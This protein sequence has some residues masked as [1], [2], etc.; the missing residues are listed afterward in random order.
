MRKLARLLIIGAL[1]ASML[2][3]IALAADF[4]DNSGASTEFENDVI[5]D[6]I[7][8]FG[9]QRDEAEP[10]SEADGEE[11]EDIENPDDDGGTEEEKDPMS[12]L[13]TEKHIQY[14]SGYEDGTFRPEDSITRY[15]VATMFA[16][17]LREE[18]KDAPAKFTDVPDSAWYAKSVNALA[19][20]EILSGREEKRFAPEEPI[21][22]GEIAAIAAKFV[23]E[24]K[25]GKEFPDV[26]ES[27][28]AYSSIDTA[29]AQGLVKGYEDGTF[30]PE[31]DISRAEVVSIINNL[32]GR[33]GDPK[34]GNY[35]DTKKFKDVVS[36]HWA[37]DAICEAA[38]THDGTID[39]STGREVWDVQENHIFAWEATDEGW[40][41]KNV[42]K[43]IF[44]TGFRHIGGLVYYFDTE[45]QLLQTGWKRI[46]G[47]HYL[48]PDKDENTEAFRKE[49]LLTNVNRHE[50]NRT[51][52][53]IK[54]ITVHYTG[55]PNDKAADWAQHFHDVNRGASAHYFVDESSIWQV[56][57]DKDIS[58]HSGTTGQYYHETARNSNSIGIEMSCRK[59]DFENATNPLDEDWYF[60]SGTEE[61]T[62]KLVQ[63]LMK[64]YGVPV[65]NIIRHTDITHKA[66]PA[67]YVNNYSQWQK[68]LGMVTGNNVE[69][70][71]DYPVKI[72]GEDIKVYS[73]PG[74]GY[75]VAGIRKNGDEETVYEEKVMGQGKY[76]RWAR[77]GNNLWIELPN[78]IRQ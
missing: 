49:T 72:F 78:M 34:A 41:F 58:W 61:N 4:E 73:G 32:L 62:V 21:K 51:W 6:G 65:E 67:P 23:E 5:Y 22:R 3:T 64:T 1:C 75:P 71:G 60:L 47:K 55:K 70:N 52:K 39:E 2:G 76:D 45:T 28:W 29:L 59:V 9:A 13:Q 8:D 7:W 26:K 27:H 18:V 77:I 31:N 38:T 69:Y 48:L 46:E 56:V 63:S 42:T 40:K 25:S 54:Y 53:D 35:G 44:V 66:C 14:I 12:L 30:R 15:E 17:L 24:K 10:G 33:T 74:R 36:T 16:M 37:F 19:H 68:F 50:A 43:D 57:E 11:D 20:L